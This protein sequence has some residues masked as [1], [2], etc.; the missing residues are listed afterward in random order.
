MRLY[1]TSSNTK[2][3]KVRLREGWREFLPGMYLLHRFL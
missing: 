1:T 2:V 3:A